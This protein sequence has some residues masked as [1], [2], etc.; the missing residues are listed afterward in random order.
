[1]RYRVRFFIVFVLFMPFFMAFSFASEK[2][3]Q[4]SPSAF[5]PRDKYKFNAVIDGAEVTHDF[6]IQNKGDAP[7]IIKDVKTG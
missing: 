4:E 3:I 1:M 5:F 7:L 2:A 6:I